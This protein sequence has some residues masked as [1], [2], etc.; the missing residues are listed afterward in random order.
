MANY[1]VEER[2]HSSWQRPV[3]D[4]DLTSPPSGPSK[5]DRYIVGASATGAWEGNDNKIAQYNGSGWDFYTQVEGWICW[6]K[7]EDKFYKYDGS[8][9][10]VLKTA[11]IGITIDGGGA[12]I[13]TGYKGFIRIPFDCVITKASLLGDDDGGSIVIDIWKCS[14]A[15]YDGG[16]TH[17][18]DGDSITASAPPTISSAS[19]S[20]DNT[21]SGWTTAISNGEILGFNV[22][23]ISTFEKVTLILEVS[24]K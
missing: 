5:G 14:Y 10:S 16:S 1:L 6:V 2:S 21:L 13:S 22:D 20:E 9:W 11:T 15:N 24:R 23:S 3:E 18:V 8:S 12:E 19:K 7:D 4:K 17:P